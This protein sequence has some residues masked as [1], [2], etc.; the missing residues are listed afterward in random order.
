MTVFAK[1]IVMLIS[2]AII[3]IPITIVIRIC[4]RILSG[5]SFVK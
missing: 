3:A 4:V 5:K 2:L 1:L